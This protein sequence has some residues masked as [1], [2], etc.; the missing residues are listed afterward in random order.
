M[1]IE[2]INI[3][4]VIAAAL[5]IFGLKQLGSPATAVRGNMLSS[6]GMLIAVVVTLFNAQIISFQWIAI[7]ALGGAIV[8]AVVAQK[9]EMT[10]MPEM[11]ALFNGSGGIASL[12]VGWA[13]LYSGQTTTFTDITILLSV[14]IGGITFSGSILAWG[15]LSEVM[16]SAAIV[17]GAQRF[18]NALILVA[19][20][21]CAVMF[22]QDPSVD[23]PYLYAVIGLSLVFG[24]MAVLPIGGADMPVVIS[25]LNSYSGLAA[26]AAGFAINNNILIVAGSMVGAAGLIL[27]FI[28]SAAIEK[29]YSTPLNS[30][31]RK[32]F[33][34]DKS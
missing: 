5:F 32:V 2:L 15:K 33:I 27:T 22:C 8:G 30:Y 11:V 6:L 16:N 31:I 7:A 34:K 26:C 3:W 19:L 4:Y 9:I 13:A 10:S 23:S 17:F 25:L 14:V 20:L 18:V 12:L 24:V 29:Y 1:N 21:V 28:I